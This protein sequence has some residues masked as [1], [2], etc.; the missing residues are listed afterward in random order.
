M[1]SSSSGVTISVHNSLV[2]SLLQKWCSDA[3]KRRWFPKLVTGKWLGAYCLSEAFSGSDAGVTN[4]VSPCRIG[5]RTLMQILDR[6]T[7]RQ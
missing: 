4:I 3:Q 7:G 1:T 2:N 5:D 6:H